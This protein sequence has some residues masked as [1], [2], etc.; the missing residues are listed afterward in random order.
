MMLVVYKSKL[1]TL[2]LVLKQYK[3]DFHQKKSCK[4][5]HENNAVADLDFI[6]DHLEIIFVCYCYLHVIFKIL[7]IKSYFHF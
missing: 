1:V 7:N 2:L 5:P 4:I 3:G 6:F